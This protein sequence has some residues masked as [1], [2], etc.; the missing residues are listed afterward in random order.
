M[1]PLP[2]ATASSDASPTLLIYGGSTAMGIAAIQFAKLSNATV[3]ATCSP[4]SFDYVKSLGADHV[5]D[6]KSPS[7]VDEIRTLANGPLDLALDCW[8]TEETAVHCA[9]ALKAGGA[10][11]SLGR[12]QEAAKT[13]NPDI[14][15][16]WTLAYVMFDGAYWF[17]GHQ[18][19]SVPDFE[20]FKVFLPVAEKLL[21]DG[22]VKPPTVFLN[23]GGEGLEGAI[24]GLDEARQGNVRGGKLV[25]TLA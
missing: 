5:V 9:K 15:T 10:Y 17:F 13:A 4:S 19:P 21:A 24:K 7:L 20:R 18:E 11:S 22:K 8:A 25:Y 6:Y 1:L 23:R 2:N 12:N 14:T 3:I 16:H